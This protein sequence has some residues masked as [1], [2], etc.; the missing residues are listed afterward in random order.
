MWKVAAIKLLLLSKSR[1]HTS[2]LFFYRLCLCP[3]LFLFP[4]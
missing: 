2:H 1:F 3:L 4:R